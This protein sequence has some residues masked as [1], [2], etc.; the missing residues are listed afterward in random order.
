MTAHLEVRD[1]RVSY[2]GARRARVT[3]VDGVNLQVQRGRSLG[4]V[5]ETGCGKSTLARAICGLVAPS[6]G[7][8]LLDGTPLPVRRD[9]A[10]ARRVQM[11]FQDPTSSLNPR[12]T[13]GGVLVELLHAHRLRAGSA[14]RDRAVEL[15]ELVELPP[16]FLD[17]YP[18]ALSGG[19]RQRVGIARALAVE[20]EVLLV[21]EAVSALDVSVQATVL[22]LLD[23]LRAQ[24]GMTVLFISH[25]LGVVRAVSDDVA[26]MRGGRI[27]E[28]APV[29]RL[30][31]APDHEYT[32]ALLAAVPRLD[33]SAGGT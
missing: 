26:V 2:P 29:A 6:A 8:V 9:R 33:A 12:R 1:L 17:R 14:A 7:E 10:T 27:V 28:Q 24:L 13:V 16:A 15:L 19:Q 20:P 5:G 32:R 4:L 11:V 31:S 21:D 3:V 23:R 22:R 25:D 30:F 18:A